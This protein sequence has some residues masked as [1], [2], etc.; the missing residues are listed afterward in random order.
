MQPCL[1]FFWFSS[2]TCTSSSEYWLWRTGYWLVVLIDVLVTSSD[3]LGTDPVRGLEQATFKFSL[4][5][6]RAHL[7]S[8][9]F[10]SLTFLLVHILFVAQ[11]FFLLF[12]FSALTTLWSALYLIATTLILF[13]MGGSKGLWRRSN[14]A[15]C[16]T[17]RELNV[18]GWNNKKKKIINRRPRNLAK[19]K[20][21]ITEN[22][23]QIWN[24]HPKIW[25]W[26]IW[27]IWFWTLNL[28]STSKTTVSATFKSLNFIFVSNGLVFTKTRKAFLKHYFFRWL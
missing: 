18:D 21:F 17:A 6:F 3:V 22:I 5:F 24:Q 11:Y 14:L 2:C 28:F 27:E 8:R 16:Y 25:I 23:L 10:I 4:C 20:W 7:T 12:S 26:K 1:L 19:F 9:S 15:N 13:D